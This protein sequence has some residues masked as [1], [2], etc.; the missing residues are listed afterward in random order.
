VIG[1]LGLPALVAI[2]WSPV[3]P[4]QQPRA[5]TFR[6]TVPQLDCVTFSEH[7]RSTLDAETGGRRRRETLTRSGVLR[8]RARAAGDSVA[9]E[10]WYD[11]LALSRQ[12]P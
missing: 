1:R 12:S 10:A 11:S 4:A 2:A 9:L 5:L 8:I 3:A 6:Y 7:S